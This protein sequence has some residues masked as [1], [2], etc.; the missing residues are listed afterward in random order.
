MRHSFELGRGPFRE[1]AMKKE[2]VM[3]KRFEQPAIKLTADD[4]ERLERLAHASRAIFPETSD[5]LAHEIDRARI[6]NSEERGFVGMGSEVQFR[7]D[8]TG[9]VR[10]VTL[11]FPNQADISTGR[12][13]ILT[14]IGAA[15]IGLSTGQ[16]IE[17]QTPAGDGRS[18][19]VLS[20]GDRAI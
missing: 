11:V 5:Y 12:I 10:R 16:S 3:H 9:Q 15:L 7:D 2:H 19:T 4:R 6:V 20:V 17:W 14:P 8:C 1:N 13:S 18:L